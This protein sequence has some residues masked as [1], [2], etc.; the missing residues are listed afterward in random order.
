[1]LI[2][3][4]SQVNA[5]TTPTTVRVFPY[6]VVVE[7]GTTPLPTSPITVNV[8][9][10]NVNDLFAWQTKLY[11]NS[12]MLNTTRDWVW[13]PPD[14]VF[15]GKT[16]VDVTPVVSTDE[17]GTYILFGASLQGD[18]P[19]FNGSGTLFQ[20]NFTG[21]A[22]GFSTLRLSTRGA[23]A[24]SEDTFL[25]NSDINDVLARE[26]LFVVVDG[27]S[28]SEISLTLTPQEVSV[29][30]V[31][32]ISGTISPPMA[33]VDVTIHYKA[34][35]KR[36]WSTLVVVKTDL[37]SHYSY[38][39]RPTKVGTFEIRAIWSDGENINSAISETKTA[40]V[41]AA[42]PTIFYVL[43]GIAIAITVVIV[44]FAKISARTKPNL[45]NEEL[46]PGREPTR[47]SSNSPRLL[48]SIFVKT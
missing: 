4:R 25:W 13:Y 16:F 37:N 10:I 19:T 23:R 26:I 48:A 40:T 45:Q 14:H 3:S 15:A 5:N 33:N 32:D 47:F 35:G 27:K 20:M 1:M 12:S 36:V 42:T 44:Y 18:T 22:E 24:L 8:T 2:P 6:W 31:I 9:V 11:F 43:I 7:K 46:C 34:I 39:W 28:S 30:R 17:E 21:I 38:I 29:T 41:K